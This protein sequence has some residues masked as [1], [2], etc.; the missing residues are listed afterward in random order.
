MQANNKHKLKLLFLMRVL[1]DET[2]SQ[3]GLT[4]PQIIERLQE[5]GIPAERKAIYRDFQ[6]LRDIG[7][8]VRCSTR[9]CAANLTS[10]RS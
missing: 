8:D 1:Q 2:D 3:Q 4:M 9:S 5:A 10:T 7:F 6:A